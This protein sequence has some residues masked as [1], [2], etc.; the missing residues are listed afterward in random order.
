MSEDKTVRSQIVE[1]IRGE[2]LQ[3]AA[4][5]EEIQLISAY[6]QGFSWLEEV[7][8]PAVEEELPEKITIFFRPFLPEGMTEWVD[9]NG[10]VPS[11]HNVKA[12]DPEKW[13]D[14]PIR[15]LQ[16]LYPIADVLEEKLGISKDDILFQPYEGKENLTYLCQVSTKTG[17]KEFRYLAHASERPYLDEFPGMG[18]VHPSTGF[19]NVW[20]NGREVVSRKIQTDLEKIWDVYQ[21]EVLPDCRRYIGKRYGEAIGPEQQPFFR[22]LTL[23]AWISEPDE[24]VGCREDLISSLDAFH[25]D[26]YFTGCDYFKQLGLEKSGVLL[27]APGL[28]LPVLHKKEGSPVLRVTLEEP[29]RDHPCILQDQKMA[30]T[31]RKRDEVSAFVSCVGLCGKKLMVTI[32]TKGVP[33]EVLAAYAELLETDV[34]E[35]GKQ[36]RSCYRMRFCGESGAEFEAEIP[37]RK[38]LPKKDIAEID[39]HESEVIGYETYLAIIEELK[40]VEGMEVFQTASSYLGR[41]QYAIWLKPEYAGYLSMT[42]RLSRIPGLLINARH[43]ANEVSSTNA[44]FQL[45]KKLLTENKY[46]DLPEKLNLVL[47][48][49]EN[50]DGAAI[51]YELQKEHPFW[52]FHV[53]RFNA[54][55]KEF[56][57]E[58]YQQDTIHS[59]AMGMTRLIEMFAPDMIV[60]NHGVPSHEWE[61]QFSGYTSPSYKG[62]WLP[63][64]LL[65]GYF[66]YVSDPEYQG[67][68]PVNEKMQD[69]IADRILEDSEMTA[70]N[71]EWSTEFERYAHAWFP[72]LFPADYYKGMINYWIPYPYNPNHTYASI[73]YPWV[74]TVSYTSEVA[75]ETA[76][77]EYLELCASAHVAHDE[78]TLTMLIG[79]KHGKL[80]RYEC[81]DH[82]IFAG[83]LRQRPMI[84]E[85]NNQPVK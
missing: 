25:E 5:P 17:Q 76:Q 14:L 2:L 38:P 72:K 60:D 39:L 46:R 9:E 65:Y 81:R 33:D 20:I 85:E 75:D 28:I 1:E 7:V 15:Y 3:R 40:Q 43:H 73:R 19:I 47:V 58:Y 31:E 63:R 80:C 55:G 8:I 24:R 68:Y 36:I 74:V 82:Q 45:L 50:P 78:A 84:V 6:K 83:L 27:D 69:V 57:H 34:L 16:E 59:E 35:L 61:Q 37:E 10:A 56:A 30:A 64:S 26:L 79:A 18:K 21:K 44:S 48:P 62:F 70:W 23:E 41:K 51:H 54:L 67:N 52:K 66:W 29:L 11:Y 22:Q 53:A 42:K 12:E 71:K 4:L 32:K 49:M 13:Y 77:G